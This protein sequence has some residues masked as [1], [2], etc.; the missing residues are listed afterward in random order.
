MNTNPTERSY[1]LEFISD[2]YKKA[3]EMLKE[4]QYKR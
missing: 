3:D 1:L 2:E 4:A